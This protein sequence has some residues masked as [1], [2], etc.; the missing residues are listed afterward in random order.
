MIT[1]ASVHAIDSSIFFSKWIRLSRY[2]YVIVCSNMRNASWCVT[3]FASITLFYLCTFFIH[4]DIIKYH[5]FRFTRMTRIKT[6]CM[7]AHWVVAWSAREAGSRGASYPLA[8]IVL[9]PREGP[10][11]ISA[12][13]LYFNQRC[14][15]SLP[16]NTRPCFYD[17]V[18]SQSLT[19]MNL[20]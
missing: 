19:R 10:C 4:N 5:R 1:C 12:L 16:L 14:Y 3:V 13:A 7:G 8:P 9:A 18:S 2:I 20:V 6:A 11:E 15:N 17:Y